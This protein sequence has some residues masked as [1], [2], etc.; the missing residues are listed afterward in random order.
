[1]AAEMTPAREVGGDLYDF[2]PLDRD[3]LFFLIG[4]VSGKG[5]PASIFM[6]VSKA[7]YKSNVLRSKA[8]G[9]DVELV[10]ELMTVANA[11]VSR[12]NGEAMFVTLFAGILDLETG[13]LAYCNA[14]HDNPAVI[15]AEGALT[16]LTGGDG[17][18]LCVLDDFE[19]DGAQVVIAPGA[20]IC[21]VTDGVTEAQNPAGDLYGGA[22]L[23][24]NQETARGLGL[25][26]A[27]LLSAVAADVAR[28]VDGAEPAD[29]LT[30]LTLRWNGPAKACA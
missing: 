11:E 14:G 27:G 17:P 25:G 24:V 28:F 29:D 16:H 23:R 30:I 7:L 26:A 1:V 19:Y 8:P 21:L 18:P 6:A 3:R 13:V 5:L 22:R 15:S 2:F 4:D 10:G 20:L 12:E 9:A